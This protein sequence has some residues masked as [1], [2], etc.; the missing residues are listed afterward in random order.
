M[1]RG[2]MIQLKA[3]SS[4]ETMEVRKQRKTCCSKHRQTEITRVDPAKY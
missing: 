2:V 3:D 4:L 1:Y